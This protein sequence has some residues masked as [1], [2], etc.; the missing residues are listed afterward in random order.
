[1]EGERFVVS[2]RTGWLERFALPEPNSCS[3]FCRGSYWCPQYTGV[4]W[5][6]DQ[7]LKLHASE[8]I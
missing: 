7:P 8:L 2:V 5:T 6:V 3:G 4:W 1:M